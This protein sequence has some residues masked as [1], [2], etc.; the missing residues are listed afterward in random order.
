M[1][2]S[3]PDG[4]RGPWPGLE[5]RGGLGRKLG[6][7]A[8]TPEPHTRE[9]AIDTTAIDINHHTGPT[10]AAALPGA[11]KK[12]AEC[13]SAKKGGDLDVPEGKMSAAF[14]L[15]AFNLGVQA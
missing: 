8:A 7:R 12:F 3:R 6:E 11:A 4:V 5:L 2:A 1:A 13:G 9:N 14:E 10:R 15:A